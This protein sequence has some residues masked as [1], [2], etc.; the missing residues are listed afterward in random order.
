MQRAPFVYDP[1]NNVNDASKKAA[2]LTGDMGWVCAG[3][4]LSKTI[5]Q[6]VVSNGIP[7]IKSNRVSAP[8][9]NKVKQQADNST[10]RERRMAYKPKPQVI[11]PIAVL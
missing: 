8:R 6:L 11:M 5:N 3:G 4:S 1:K 7:A 10:G 9:V 2:L